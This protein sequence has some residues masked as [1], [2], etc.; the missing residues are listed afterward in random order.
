MYTYLFADYAVKQERSSA[1]RKELF[2]QIQLQDRPNHP[3]RKQP[4]QLLLDMPIRWS[5]TYVMLERS[6]TLK[7]VSACYHCYTCRRGH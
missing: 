1:Q 7:D 2:R 3:P 6:D 5:S 4:L